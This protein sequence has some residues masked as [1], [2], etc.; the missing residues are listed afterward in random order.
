[1]A[2]D[3]NA[4]GSS[5]V[6]AVPQVRYAR[7]WKAVIRGVVPSR[8]DDVEA[9]YRVARHALGVAMHEVHVDRVL[10]DVANSDV[11]ARNEHAA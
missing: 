3:T 2:D 6:P 10:D 1:M 8:T 11:R 5:E 7:L 9:W 4:A